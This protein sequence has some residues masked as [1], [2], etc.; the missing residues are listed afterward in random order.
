[1]L[2][3]S[4]HMT[5]RGQI[6]TRWSSRVETT[7]GRGVATDL[8]D[9]TKGSFPATSISAAA[10]W[11][12]SKRSKGW[13]FLT[14]GEV[15]DRLQ[16]HGSKQWHGMYVV[17]YETFQPI[18]TVKY[19]FLSVYLQNTQWNVNIQIEC[20]HLARYTQYEISTEVQIKARDTEITN[21]NIN[22]AYLDTT[23]NIWRSFH[24]RALAERFSLMGTCD[25]LT[26]WFQHLI[27]Q[28]SSLH[29]FFPIPFNL[30]MHHT[31]RPNKRKIKHKLS[32][33]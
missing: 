29:V 23:Q 26:K 22:R 12:S 33:E 19:M 4:D 15:T 20:S 13:T 24:I 27:S 11:R 2:Y 21:G 6:R 9:I 16:T 3:C 14:T 31:M 5:G 1:M 18:T 10:F 25:R 32:A 28:C 17:Q 7:P 8:C 30:Y